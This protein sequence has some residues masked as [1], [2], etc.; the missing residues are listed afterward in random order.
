MISK[1]N[2]LF[3]GAGPIIISYRKKY[4]N[5]KNIRIFTRSRNKELND[6]LIGDFIY[7]DLNKLLQKIDVVIFSIS[8]TKSMINSEEITLFKNKFAEFLNYCKKLKIE[9]FIF[10]SSVSV[11]KNHNEKPSTEKDAVESSSNYAEEK[12]NFEK[13][14]IST[15]KDSY[16]SYSIL[17]ISNPFGMILY[18]KRVN[19]FI[20]S[21]FEKNKNMQQIYVDNQGKSL[22]D[23]IFIDDLSEI[24][25][26]FIYTQ[27]NINGVFNVGS[28]KSY[29]LNEVIETFKLL[30]INLR[31]SM[32]DYIKPDSSSININKL[33]RQSDF[34]YTDLLTSIEKIEKGVK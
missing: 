10:L 27:K 26:H 32:K 29:S 13:K 34:K 2:V 16:I 25:H 22:R 14:I 17:R 15:F 5:L 7:Y 18:T 23:F 19:N 3:V 6:A 21:I 8:P 33:L 24:L 28:G 11:Y 31:I 4:S 30:N 20:D 9:K 1:K 12:I